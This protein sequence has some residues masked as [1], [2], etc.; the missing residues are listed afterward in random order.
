MCAIVCLSAQADSSHKQA[1]N[2]L[3]KQFS[4]AMKSN[5]KNMT[6]AQKGCGKDK[7]GKNPFPIPTP[8]G[9]GKVKE[10]KSQKGFGKDK[11]GKNPYPIQYHSRT[12]QRHTSNAMDPFRVAGRPARNYE[13]ELPIADAELPELPIAEGELPIDEADSDDSS[14]AHIDLSGDPVLDLLDETIRR[15]Q[16]A[17]RRI[18][19]GTSP[20]A[21]VKKEIHTGAKK[22]AEQPLDDWICPR[23]ETP[24]ANSKW[25]KDHCRICKLKRDMMARYARELSLDEREYQSAK[26]S[27]VDWGLP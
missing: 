9:Y 8:K 25:S 26:S 3:T 22:F 18:Q 21:V 7:G 23:C 15:I 14:E 20:R 17:R 11:Y 6:N 13:G 24:H 27:D 16:E 5:D 10:G 1:S 19:R 4:F 12:R 2:L